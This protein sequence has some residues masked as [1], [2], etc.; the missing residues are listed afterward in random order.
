[1]FTCV[2]S[3]WTIGAVTE[4]YLSKRC[5]SLGFLFFLAFQLKGPGAELARRVHHLLSV[6]RVHANVGVGGSVYL[7]GST[8]IHEQSLADMQEV[9]NFIE[10]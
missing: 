9:I 2:G 6:S 4:L 1:M 8:K 3:A 5:Y 10:Q 7:P